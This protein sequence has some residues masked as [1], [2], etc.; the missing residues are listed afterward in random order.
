MMKMPTD[1]QKLIIDKMNGRAFFNE[2]TGRLRYHNPG[3]DVLAAINDLGGIRE[4]AKKLD[5]NE[6]FIDLWI[7]EYFVPDIY[8]E[9]IYQLI[10]Y[11]ASSLQQPPT[12]A[13]IEGIYWPK[14]GFM[15]EMNFLAQDENLNP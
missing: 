1:I 13:V 15:T 14:S 10:D 3:N 2:K 5:V 7:D 12:Y 6:D 11:S 4:A 8:A 9:K